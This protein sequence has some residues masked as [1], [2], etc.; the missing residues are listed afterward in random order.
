MNKTFWFYYGSQPIYAV[1][2]EEY[3]TKEEVLEKAIQQIEVIS[4]LNEDF[5]PHEL[6]KVLKFAD[7]VMP[8]E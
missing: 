6:V 3:A 5:T 1:R 2:A 8:T 7:I 4:S